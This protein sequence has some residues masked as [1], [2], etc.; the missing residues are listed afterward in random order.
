MRL[1]D[2][3]SHTSPK[4]KNEVRRLQ[5]AL[6]EKGFALKTDG[7]FGRFTEAA[8]KEFQQ[9]QGIDADG[10][11]GPKTWK[12][13]IGFEPSIFGYPFPTDY[14][15]D[16]PVLLAEL[17]K[18]IDYRAFID[19]AC[20]LH[21]FQPSVIGGI[22]SRESRWG[23]A[24]RPPGPGG[25]G[26]FSKRTP[27]PPVRAGVLPP[28]GCGFGR[29]LMQI[30]YDF[31]EF[32]RG[33]DW[34]NARMTILYG[35]NVLADSQKYLKQKIG[36]DGLNLLMA[37]VAAYNCGAGNVLKA[38]QNGLDVDYYSAG[39]NYSRNTLSRAGWFQLQGL[40]VI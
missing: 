26:D 20:A 33:Q 5:K 8:V 11:A 15:R 31:H 25:T 24:L 7:L 12:K 17:E 3:Y 28:D 22:G 21:G 1:F 4:L 39:R 10:V 36:W 6:K 34:K 32:A 40:G 9:S 19:E 27:R 23:L 2:G 14:R 16:D 18:T 29:G 13:L 38:I 30:D 37:S 35:A